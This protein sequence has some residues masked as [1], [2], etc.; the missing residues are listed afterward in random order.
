LLQALLLP[1]QCR[2]HRVCCKLLHM[3]RHVAVEPVRD[4]DV[5]VAEHF[6]P[7]GAML[8]EHKRTPRHYET[9]E[10]GLRVPGNH[11]VRAQD[12]VD[13]GKQLEA[14]VVGLQGH[15]ARARAEQAGGQLA[16]ISGYPAG[17]SLSQ[18]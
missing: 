6:R 8:S 5:R 16:A 18:A 3:R 12:C 10:I 2:I 15:D 14:S 9:R 13:P 17:Y 11:R 1:S 7:A 4:G